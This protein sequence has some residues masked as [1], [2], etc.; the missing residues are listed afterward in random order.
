MDSL[1]LIKTLGYLALFLGLLYIVYVLNRKKLLFKHHNENSRLTVK[2][3]RRVDQHLSLTIID[4]DGQEFLIVSNT[5]GLVV[6]K[7]GNEK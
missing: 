1:F 3:Y 6:K 7:L 4:S 5:N 2:S